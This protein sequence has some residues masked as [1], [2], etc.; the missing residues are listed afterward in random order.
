MNPVMMIPGLP[1][2]P[3]F[4]PNIQ[5]R[6]EMVQN[7]KL[8]TGYLLQEI[9][10]K[11]MADRSFMLN[12]YNFVGQNGFQN[13]HF[14][15]L[16]YEVTTIIDYLIANTGEHF[17]SVIAKVIPSA[18]LSVAVTLAQQNPQLLASVP[19]N[20]R[21]QMGQT[22]THYLSLLQTA[23]NWLK[24][25]MMQNY[26]P[27]NFFPGMQPQAPVAYQGQY[28]PQVAGA[29][30]PV[31]GGVM[32]PM[33]NPAVANPHAA[34]MYMQQ[35]Q[36]AMLAQ[37]QNLMRQQVQS[38]G[39]APA[40]GYLP[41]QNQPYV[42][43]VA[44]AINVGYQPAAFQ[45]PQQVSGPRTGGL[46][47]TGLGQNQQPQ[48]TAEQAAYVPQAAANVPTYQQPTALQPQQPAGYTQQAPVAAAT[49]QPQEPLMSPPVATNTGEVKTSPITPSQA[50]DLVNNWTVANADTP[51][52]CVGKNNTITRL[53]YVYD[54]TKEVHLVVLA[55]GVAVEQKVEQKGDQ[56]EL[57]EHETI[58]YFPA[59]TAADRAK[60]DVELFTQQ[61]DKTLETIELS[62]IL[63]DIEALQD[64]NEESLAKETAAIVKNA[65]TKGVYVDEPV[66]SVTDRYR[67]EVNQK[68]GSK[69]K[70]SASKDA[71]V[72]RH[73]KIEPW[74][75][76]ESAAAY[77]SNVTLS[78]DLSD[79]HRNLSLLVNRLAPEHATPLVDRVTDHVN[80]ELN[81]YFGLGLRLDS[82]ILDFGEMLE[83][84]GKNHSPEFV[85][86]VLQHI[87]ERLTQTIL[88]AYTEKEVKEI[89]N[90]A[91][92][93]GIDE[94]AYMTIKELVFLPVRSRDI[95][96]AYNGKA[97]LLLNTEYPSLT[98][99]IDSTLE[100]SSPHTDEMLI[101]TL[102]D[103]IMRIS[104]ILNDNCFVMYK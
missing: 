93:I 24:G 59:R 91:V 80:R 11:A 3:P 34:A 57:S 4:V 39:N 48:Q 67:A 60:P 30:M 36:N 73:I 28:M 42:P 9:Q 86:K 40:Q 64:P 94:R 55:N 63:A 18:V 33:M 35:Q 21:N 20:V 77:A 82:F 88:Y 85:T 25:A 29:M 13:E 65:L 10:S 44:G 54:I 32:Q 97:G 46:G 31:Q 14:T 38:F 87:H 103:D 98:R 50:K 89:T 51:Y 12:M 72:T 7:V 81:R 15:R 41:P 101:I 79:L 26:N 66:V 45:Q 83:V 62:K 5:C 1:N 76:S 104:P 102:D 90:G 95:P 58:H 22:T 53:P 49:M 70:I 2:N 43:Q 17:N 78:V 84:L 92:E 47:T 69:L 52:K 56:V 71:V 68:L 100:K 27:Q 75:M 96:Y 61:L 8:I 74:A 19:Q 37:Q 6:P 23:D 16:V 99:L